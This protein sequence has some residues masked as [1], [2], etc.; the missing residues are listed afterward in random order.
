MP[1]FC[2]ESFVYYSCQ[3]FKRAQHAFLLVGVMAAI[4]SL[5]MSRHSKKK[6]PLFTKILLPLYGFMAASVAMIILIDTSSA[7]NLAA[8][9]LILIAFSLACIHLSVIDALEIKRSLQ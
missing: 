8:Q 5:E 3:Y 1:W 6:A 9:K 7:L 4:N 2:C